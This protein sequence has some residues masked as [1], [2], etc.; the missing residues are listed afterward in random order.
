MYYLQMQI[1]W[2]W[3]LW[4][5]MVLTG[6]VRAEADSEQVEEFVITAKREQEH[7]FEVDRSL[8]LVS[9]ENL[10]ESQGQSLPESLQESCG[11]F[12][13]QTNRGGGAP[14]LRGMIGP[15][16]LI[17]IDGIRFNNSSFRTGPNQYLALIDPSSVDRVEILLGPGSVMYGSDALGGVVQVFPVAWP[18]KMGAG[19]RGGSRFASPDLS[20][21]VWADGYWQNQDAQLMVGGAFGNFESLRAGQGR[22]QAISDYQNGAWR[23]RAR[24]FLSEHSQL[25]LT[26]LGARVRHAGRADRLYEGRYRFYDN[27]DDFAYLDWNSQFEGHLRQVRMAVSFHRSHERVDGYR[28][29]MDQDPSAIDA[30]ACLAAGDLGKEQMPLAPLH[31]QQITADTV[32]SPGALAMVKF[33]FLDQ[34]LRLTTGV[35]AYYDQVESDKQQRSGDG[36]LAWQWQDSDRGNFSDG[37]SYR[38]LGWYALLDAVIAAGKTQVLILGGGARLSNFAAAADDVPGIG[39]VSYAHSGIV[40][41]A[42]IRYLYQ[43]QAMA[44]ANFSQGF[45]APNLQETTV[46]G[47]TGSKFEVPNADLSPEQSNTLEIG[48]R[49]NLQSIQ[50]FLSAHVSFLK[51]VI[52]ERI[53]TENE[54]RAMGLDLVGIGD[55]PVVQ[56]VNNL[57]GLYWGMEAS[58][59]AGPW[60]NLRPWLRVAWIRGEIDS[61]DGL[62][63]PARRIPPWMGTLG[64]RYQN[65]TE[66][67][68]VELFSRFA[69]PQE[70]LH[71]ADEQDLRICEDPANRGD[72][73]ADSGQR[74]P[75]TPGWITLNLRGGVRC[76]KALRLEISATNLTDKLYRM[77]GSGVEAPGIGVSLSLMASY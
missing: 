6:S 61:A 42:G 2:V 15:Q 44:Y 29:L 75:G 38:S 47:D 68:Y 58:L 53:L 35:E 70:K 73:Y 40:T 32:L 33:G 56:R 36:E 48:A 45:R 21:R 62:T 28:C 8:H 27:D 14:I 25:G 55:K 20:T 74:C 37:S 22:E 41:M 77:H 23:A 72:S 43:D 51:D 46:L 54:W 69:G 9:S 26:Y 63:Y 52:D 5:M 71:P 30:V 49:L 59:S 67:F 34:R 7:T 10:I 17:L 65:P 64:L 12:V 76:G 13:Q 1:R 60:A 11:V 66:E 24:Y 31:Q 19:L 50:A 3:L 4:A 18:E 16:N 57:S 39:E